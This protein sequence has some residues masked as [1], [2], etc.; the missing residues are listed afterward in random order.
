MLQHM[1]KNHELEIVIRKITFEQV[2]I[3]D[4][5][6]FVTDRRRTLDSPGFDTRFASQLDQRSAPA[7]DVEHAITGTEQ[8]PQPSPFPADQSGNAS[9]DRKKEFPPLLAII[10]FI[11]IRREFRF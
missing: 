2:F 10:V 9:L 7:S 11:V 4:P 6:K 1:P 5:R 3:Q 8:R